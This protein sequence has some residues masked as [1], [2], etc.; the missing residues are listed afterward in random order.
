MWP[1]VGNNENPAFATASSD[2][3]ELTLSNPISLPGKLHCPFQA[4]S[5][6][7]LTESKRR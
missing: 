7:L 5:K 4:S 3:L 6:L 2:C 1:G